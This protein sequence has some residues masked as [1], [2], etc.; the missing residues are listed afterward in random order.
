MISLFPI[1]QSVTKV[2]N[3]SFPQR[4]LSINFEVDAFV[5]FQEFHQIASD[6]HTDVLGVEILRH[7][8]FAVHHLEVKQACPR[9]G[10]DQRGKLVHR[11]L[12]QLVDGERNVDSLDETVFLFLQ[13]LD[14]TDAE[15]QSTGVITVFHAGTNEQVHPSLAKLGVIDIIFAEKGDFAAAGEVF[16][17]DNAVG[18]PFLGYSLA[19][20][21]DDSPEKEVP[22]EQTFFVVDFSHTGVADIGQNDAV[23]VQ[24]MR[25]KVDADQ[26]FLFVQPLEH[27][28]RLAFRNFGLGNRH[29]IVAAK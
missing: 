4:N 8:M 12:V 11:R 7:V 23:I 16:D 21:G 10:F 27:A 14:G 28:P 1:V 22:A 25:G 29:K 17:L 18:R 3:L 6:V 15:A 2:Q 13:Q 5:L 19:I 24:R 26:L 20:I 9:V